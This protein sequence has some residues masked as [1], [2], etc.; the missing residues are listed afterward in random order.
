MFQ[1]PTKVYEQAK[2]R[3]LRTSSLWRQAVRK[4]RHEIQATL[5]SRRDAAAVAAME[6]QRKQHEADAQ[7]R[8][9]WVDQALQQQ[10]KLGNMTCPVCCKDAGECACLSTSLEHHLPC[11]LQGCW[12]VCVRGLTGGKAYRCSSRV[13]CLHADQ[14]A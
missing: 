10:H 5:A 6:A 1:H 3:Y 12:L 8:L 9:A 13:W 7:R 4:W 11:L 2:L 14:S